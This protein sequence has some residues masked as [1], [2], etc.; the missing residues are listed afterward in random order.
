M[1]IAPTDRTKPSAVV[2]NA[3]Y[4]PVFNESTAAVPLLKSR[5]PSVCVIPITVPKNPNMGI[6]QT[7]IL[8]NPYE[9]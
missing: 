1:K 9:S 2:S 5:P 4:K 7:T 3:T 6:A 8:T